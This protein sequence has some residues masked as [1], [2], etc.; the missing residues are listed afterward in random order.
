MENTIYRIQKRK[1]YV[2]LD[3]DF[4]KNNR[5]SFKAKGILALML[6]YPSDWEFREKE[7]I[8]QSTNGKE[9]FRSG[10][11][12]LINNGYIK[13]T[14]LRNDKGQFIGVEWIVLESP[15]LIT[16]QY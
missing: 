15:E 16:E 14:S 11:K 9:A 3:K 6:S 5:L 4:L 10:V 13:K 1:N 12:E 2:V 7:I 8:R